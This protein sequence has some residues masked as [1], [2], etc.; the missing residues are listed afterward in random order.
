[1]PDKEDK[2][3]RNGTTGLFAQPIHNVLAK[4]TAPAMQKQGYVKAKILTG[5]PEIVG[6][7]LATKCKPR[8]ITFKQKQQVGGTLTLRVQ[9]AFA[10]EIQHLEPLILEKLAI[11]L[12]YRAID[13]I[14]LEQA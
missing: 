14:R 8:Q 1:M 4:V 10:V 12:G 3:R 11:Y 2:I 6:T 5:W 13:K 9:G 7:E